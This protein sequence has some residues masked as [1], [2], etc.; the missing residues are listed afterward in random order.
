MKKN[1]YKIKKINNYNKIYF[2]IILRI[3]YGQK[4]D[5]FI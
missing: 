1:L 2:S 3:I 4:C 5:N